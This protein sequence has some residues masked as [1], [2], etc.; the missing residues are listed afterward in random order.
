MET[1]TYYVGKITAR[2][3]RNPVAHNGL[4]AFY[5]VGDVV[6]IGLVTATDY[7]GNPVAATVGVTAP[8]GGAVTIGEDGR[9]SAA[10]EGEYVVTVRYE[11]ENLFLEAV[12]RFVVQSGKINRKVFAPAENMPLEGNFLDYGEERLRFLSGEGMTYGDDG[13]ALVVNAK[14]DGC[15]ID[16]SILT[17]KIDL[18]KIDRITFAIKCFAA[19]ATGSQVFLKSNGAD[20][21]LARS[22]NSGAVPMRADVGNIVA[23]RWCEISIF[24]DRFTE[25]FGGAAEVSQ[26]HFLINPAT[27]DGY[28]SMY[29]EYAISSICVKTESAVLKAD[30]NLVLTEVI[31]NGENKVFALESNADYVYGNDAHSIKIYATG[32]AWIDFKINFSEI[33]LT[34][35]EKI[36]FYVMRTTPNANGAVTVQGEGGAQITL[37]TQADMDVNQW[38]RI[39]IPASRFAEVFGSAEKASKLKIIINN[40]AADDNAYDYQF[41]MSSIFAE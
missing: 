13:Y 22:G 24:K 40:T 25:F 9:F 18:S 37:T 33:D 32:G 31:E 16:F 41:F 8:D 5:T 34:K 3:G 29:Y 7:R 35:T 28:Q 39:E 4:N 14:E 20:R 2:A 27:A 36:Y 23:G 21:L 1:L 26:F 17:E 30:E 12:Y 10:M 6:D 38:T 15:W 19:N 11:E